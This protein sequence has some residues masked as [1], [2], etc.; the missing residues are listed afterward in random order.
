MLITRSIVYF[1]NIHVDAE[2]YVEKRIWLARKILTKK[3]I[4][5]GPAL[6]EIKLIL[7]PQNLMQFTTST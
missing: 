6:P 2:G 3:S 1:K 4:E 7:E 5:G